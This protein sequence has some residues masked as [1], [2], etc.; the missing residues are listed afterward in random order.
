M[1]MKIST[2]PQGE[3]SRA[4]AQLMFAYAEA[5][6]PRI[7]LIA[8]NA[9][10]MGYTALASRA[11]ADVV[12]AWPGACISAVTPK[13]AAQLNYADEM[14]D[15]ADPFAKRAELEQ[16]Y[17]EE[18]A[19]GVNA[20]KMGYVDDVIEPAQTRQMIAAALEMLAGKRES[21][22]A[23]KHGNMPL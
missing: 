4:G 1:G 2:A 21:K 7:A 22:P 6:A 3:L 14:K 10:G 16:R 15:A 20:A 17:V 9:V 23:K 11:A 8:G 5:S 13:I 19:D 18:V 12:Y